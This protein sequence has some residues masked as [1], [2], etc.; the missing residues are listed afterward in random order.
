MNNINEIDCIIAH[1][2]NIEI[3][4]KQLAKDRESLEED[5]M[6]VDLSRIELISNEYLAEFTEYWKRSDILP[7]NRFIN[8]VVDLENPPSW[9]IFFGLVEKERILN[10]YATNKKNWT[11]LDNTRNL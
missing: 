10:Y 1:P 6:L 8:W 5:G 9:A 2:N 3:L 7:D 4:K 11:C